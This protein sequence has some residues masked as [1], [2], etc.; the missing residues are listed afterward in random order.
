MSTAL[1]LLAAPVQIDV[2]VVHAT[3]GPTHVDTGLEKMRDAFEKS[4]LHFSSYRRLSQ[5]TVA[6]VVGTPTEVALPDKT[7]TLS[8]VPGEHKRPEVAVSVPPLK[9]TVPSGQR[10][11]R[12]S[13]PGR[14]RAVSWCSSSP[15]CSAERRREISRPGA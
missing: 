12:S 15:R 7:A 13:R 2:Q 1:V 3:N 5:Q 6:L 10:R 11:R 9:T 4:G 8:L 14:M